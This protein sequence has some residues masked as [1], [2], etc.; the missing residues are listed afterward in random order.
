VIDEKVKGSG[1]VRGMGW[2]GHFFSEKCWPMG[3]FGA[4]DLPWGLKGIGENFWF[5]K[6]LSRC[7]IRL[8]KCN[9]DD[10]G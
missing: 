8:K 9:S 4:A 7:S 2:Y 1:V 6:S 10:W 3:A 5:L